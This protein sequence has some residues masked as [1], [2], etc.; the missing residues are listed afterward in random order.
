M[1]WSYAALVQL[2]L[3][4]AVVFHAGG[5]QGGSATLIENFR[6]GRY[7]AVPMLQWLGMAYD[8]IQAPSHGVAPYPH[9]VQWLRA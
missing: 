9:M 6:Q 8:A 4:L 5:Y 2:E 3:D 7:V 1:A